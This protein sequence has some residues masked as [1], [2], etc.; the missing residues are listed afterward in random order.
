MRYSELGD[1]CIELTCSL[2]H[3]DS[4]KRDNTLLKVYKGESPEGDLQTSCT[5]SL[6]WVIYMP[7]KFTVEQKEQIV[8]E[9]FTATSIAELRRRHEVSVAQF[10]R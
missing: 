1:D 8:I 2:Y 9:S 6:E 3:L 5:L 4:Y 7:E 10:Q